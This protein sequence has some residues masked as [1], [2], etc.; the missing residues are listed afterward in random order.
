LANTDRSKLKIEQSEIKND[1]SELPFG[2]QKY[3]IFIEI[4]FL[5]IRVNSELYQTNLKKLQK[6][7]KI[8]I[9]P[10]QRRAGQQLHIQL[11]RIYRRH[12]RS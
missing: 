8:R 12:Y 2:F 3:F 1:E 4:S 6:Y 11:Y 10:L 5:F 7:G 9:I